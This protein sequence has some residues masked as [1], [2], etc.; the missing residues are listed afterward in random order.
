VKRPENR[1][2]CASANERF[3][4]TAAGCADLKGSAGMPPLRQ[5]A[6]PLSASGGQRGGKPKRNLKCRKKMINLQNELTMRKITIIL[7][8]LALFLS[9]CKQKTTSPNKQ[10]MFLQND[11]LNVQKQTNETPQKS[12]VSPI[13]F[14]DAEKIISEATKIGLEKIEELV[15]PI[16]LTH[17]DPSFC[18][19]LMDLE[20]KNG[21]L[22]KHH[23]NEK[24]P[25][26][27]IPE[28]TFE[29]AKNYN[30]KEAKR[31]L[32]E[33]YIQVPKHIKS[34]TIYYVYNRLNDF[35]KVLVQSNIPN[36]RER[37]L[38]DYK[39]WSNLAK[40]SKPKTYLSKEE[41]IEEIRNKS[42]EEL[43]KFKE[44]DLY[45]DCSYVAL[46]LAGAL[47]YLKVA[48]FDNELLESLK[49]QQTYPY[50]GSYEFR[51]FNSTPVSSNEYKRT[52]PNK[53]DIRNFKDDYLKVEK[54]LFENIDSCCE[55][56]I[57]EIIYDKS[58]AYVNVVRNNGSDDYLLIL[59]T[60]NTITIK[61]ISLIII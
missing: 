4:A 24:I 43:L 14:V 17:L 55:A 34:D 32:F 61:W 30:N 19:T 54:L 11:T 8:V 18:I 13:K 31:R 35:L 28:Y 57:W 10:I 5:A 2:K 36:L 22:D 27:N 38:Q 12:K 48:G 50:A 51:V 40:V 25:I 59:N 6:I 3:G 49:K 41:H 52:V 37:L 26:Y 44:D 46:Q 60:D 20:F 9:C 21:F 23:S 7:S 1:A 39:E 56:K 42:L 53:Y 45:V 47:N 58:K 15:D 33:Y 29:L 16:I